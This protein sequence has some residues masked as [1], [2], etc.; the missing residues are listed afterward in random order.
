MQDNLAID[1]DFF[2]QQ[3]NSLFL[4]L[5]KEARLLFASPQICRRLQRDLE[6][7][8]QDDIFRYIY[9][10]DREPLK[11]LLKDIPNAASSYS[12]IKQRIQLELWDGSPYEMFWHIHYHQEQFYFI[13]DTLHFSDSLRD[14]FA[15]L[16]MMAN[17]GNWY[18]F[19]DRDELQWSEQLFRMH[20][21]EEPGSLSL[22]HMID[23]ISPESRPL[24]RELLQECLRDGRFVDIELRMIS[25]KQQ[26]K[27]VRI[28]M[29]RRQ[30]DERFFVAGS[31][32]DI[33]DQRRKEK[34]LQE[35]NT[36]LVRSSRLANMGEMAN[37]IAHEIN[38]PLS[39]IIGFAER[40]ANQ[41]RKENP[42]MR[43][44]EEAAEKISQMTDRIAKI[45]RA[46]RQFSRDA[47]KDAKEIL[48][49]SELVDDALQ[50]CLEKFAAANLE[51]WIDPICQEHLVKLQRV[52]LSQAIYNLLENAFE[53]LLIQGTEQGWLRVH[54]ELNG[55]R[56]VIYIT[57]SGPGIAPEIE[58]KIMNP[59]FTTKEIGKGMGLGLPIAKSSVE[60]MHGKLYLNKT[61]KNTQFVIELPYNSQRLLQKQRDKQKKKS[62]AA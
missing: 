28:L 20:D 35:Q 14:N 1:L 31:Y 52:E 11:N 10:T 54:S 44:I 15:D 18:Y 37:G 6:Q 39:I 21:I 9:P 42:Q 61:A 3:H 34:L 4:L 62:V 23:F 32:Q 57:D 45:I 53:S 8:K 43:K 13:A 49:V 30:T 55:D 22:K 16:S 29:Q 2:F 12:Q 25:R 17:I 5:D 51:V 56:V 48:S 60:N 36:K 50:L 19:E 26:E 58:A 59:F 33:S 38:N 41:S 7:L 46:L 47:S 40:I 24:F 27:F